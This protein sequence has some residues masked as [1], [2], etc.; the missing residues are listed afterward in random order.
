MLLLHK[1]RQFASPDSQTATL[2]EPYL[3][4]PDWKYRIANKATWDGL[5]C[6]KIRHQLYKICMREVGID[7]AGL[8]IPTSISFAMLQRSKMLFE[9]DR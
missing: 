5:L 4:V 1:V 3:Q 9:A 8:M 6:Y 7:K 2:P